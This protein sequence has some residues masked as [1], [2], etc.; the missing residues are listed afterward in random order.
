MDSATARVTVMVRLVEE[1]GI[2]PE[3]ASWAALE[4]ISD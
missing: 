3:L 2:E 1:D 4:L